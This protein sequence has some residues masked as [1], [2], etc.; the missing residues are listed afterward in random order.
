MKHK[1]T[2]HLRIVPF[3]TML[4]V[5]A[6]LHLLAADITPNPHQVTRILE[7]GTDTTLS[8]LASGGQLRKRGEGDR[9]SVV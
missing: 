6:A 2:P 1:N 9:K 3:A 8:D 5:A 7:F 4:T